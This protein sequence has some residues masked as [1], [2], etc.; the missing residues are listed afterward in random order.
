MEVLDERVLLSLSTF[1]AAD[2]T[3]YIKGDAANDTAYFRNYGN[4][5]TSYIL[6]QSNGQNQVF[7][8]TKKLVFTSGSG[9]DFFENDT[10]VP[11]DMT[12]GP[13]VDVL[14]GGDGN[15]IFRAMSDTGGYVGR[16]G[17]NVL[18]RNGHHASLGGNDL[19]VGLVNGQ[20]SP[21]ELA[22]QGQLVVS[23]QGNDL[24][25]NG[26]TGAGF[27]LHSNWSEFSFNGS[28]YYYSLSPVTM[29]TAVGNLPV[30]AGGWFSIAAQQSPIPDVGIYQSG[31][32]STTPL[33]NDGTNGPLA[34]ILQNSGLDVKLSPTGL[35]FGVALGSQIKAMNIDLPVNSAVPYLYFNGTNQASISL[36]G[37]SVSPAGQT[38]TIAGA[39]DPSDPSLVVRADLGLEG[40]PVEKFA[41]GWSTKGE[42]PFTPKT[43]PEGFNDQIFGNIY[44][45]AQVKIGDYPVDIDGE[46]VIDLDAKNLGQT[47]NLG[48]YGIQELVQGQASLQTLVGSLGNIKVG[49]NGAGSLDLSK[50]IAKEAPVSLKVELS[51]GTAIFTPDLIAFRVE[52]ANLF[53]NTPLSGVVSSS[54]FDIEGSYHLS[55]HSWSFQAQSS[56]AKIANYTFGTI[57]IG[58]SSDS[59][60]IVVSARFTPP[61][62]LNALSLNGWLDF[63]GNFSLT[64][65]ATPMN[66][67]LGSTRI[68]AGARFTLSNTSGV[69]QFIAQMSASVEHTF[70]AGNLWLGRVSANIFATLSLTVSGSGVGIQGSGSFEGSLY[71]PGNHSYGVD[72]GVSFW[73]HGLLVHLPYLPDLVVTW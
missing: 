53:A 20:L 13:G 62:G 64:G 50:A 29:S 59:D 38:V 2:G 36:G 42:I 17:T 46:M 70:Y 51:E 9:S 68:Y 15:D 52:S 49:V 71:L 54:S 32:W 65:I 1:S 6:Q 67:G 21:Y 33:N 45:S 73:D 43:T 56:T 58:A 30:S 25:L 39:F 26:P 10:S 5:G 18:F 19:T 48:P 44:T 24:T 3:L 55:D 23:R 22:G 57:S 27:E 7:T 60:Q 66:I 63:H 8:G 47:P 61:L 11:G 72:V 16:G 34:S 31:S 12:G 69:V 4:T 40:N 28:N 41:F 37:W 35:Q 14:I